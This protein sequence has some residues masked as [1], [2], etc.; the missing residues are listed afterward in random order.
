MESHDLLDKKA[1]LAP[2]DRDRL[3]RLLVA[4][5]EILGDNIIGAYMHGSAVLDGLG[6]RSD[7]DVL[8]VVEHPT[9]QAQ[10]QELLDR[11]IAISGRGSER[12]VELTTVV[13]S[14]I[15]P[16]R[17]PP[18]MDFQYGEWL[19]REI[20]AGSELRPPESPNPDLASLLTMVLLGD[21][22]LIGPPPADVLDPIPTRDFVDAGIRGIGELLDR[23]DSD[24]RN[25][26]LTLARIWSA[27][28]NQTVYS[29]DGAATW[30]LSR[31]PEIHRP[32]LA[33]ARAIYR[34]EE[35]DRWDDIRE[36]I[37]PY[38]DYVVSQIDQI[39]PV[40]SHSAE[41]N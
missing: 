2:E 39:A 13:H 20:E 22:P 11:L 31:L 37:R 26:I 18:A 15:R 38:A 16:W 34:G 29:K 23:L 14:D 6:P 9:G 5:R 21:W 19:R 12:H 30:A 41:L 27:V 33:R 8:V 28:A 4:I 3:N 7:L 25:V 35:Q 1:P 17:Y 40:G 10:K 36:Q 24:T 32:A